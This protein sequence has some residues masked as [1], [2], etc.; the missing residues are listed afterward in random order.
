M[1]SMNILTKEKRIQK[2][3]GSGAFFS[4]RFK[5]KTGRSKKLTAIMAWPSLTGGDNGKILRC[6]L[7]SVIRPLSSG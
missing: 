6:F 1:V 2:Q 5:D 4:G 7:S 3:K